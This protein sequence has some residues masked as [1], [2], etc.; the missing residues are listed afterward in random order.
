MLGVQYP[1][2]Y[3]C[4]RASGILWE[5]RKHVLLIE[6]PQGAKTSG[7]Q[8]L[9]SRST[10]IVQEKVAGRA[11]IARSEPNGMRRNEDLTKS[12]GSDRFS[13]SRSRDPSRSQDERHVPAKVS[14]VW[15]H[16]LDSGGQIAPP[17]RD[18]AIRHVMAHR[19]SGA[20]LL[21]SSRR[22][23]PDA[24]Q[25][26][27]TPHG[28][29]RNADLTESFGSDRFSSSRLQKFAISGSTIRHIMAHRGSGAYLLKSSRR[30]WPGAL[31]VRAKPQECAEMQI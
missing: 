28:L 11:V 13:S 16:D 7:A 30:R 5:F 26:C 15:E 29:R 18:L 2:I 21:K 23:R 14:H 8:G 12:F 19:G 1:E 3:F 10:Q 22:R 31:P 6:L 27:L 24:L 9:R 20:D 25:V 17:R 4:V